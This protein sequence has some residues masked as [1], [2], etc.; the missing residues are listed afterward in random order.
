[1][2]RLALVVTVAACGARA[3]LSTHRT[4]PAPGV[5]TAPPGE[6]PPAA[7]GP[8]TEALAPTYPRAADGGVVLS[9][10]PSPHRERPAPTPPI[11]RIDDARAL[12][13]RRD[14]RPPLVAALAWSSQLVGRPAP[15]VDDAAGLIAWAQAAAAWRSVPALAPG[16]LIVFDRAVGGAPAS[17]VAVALGADDRG[18]V[19]MIYLGAGIVR[20]GFLDV[21][22][23]RLRRDRAGRVVNTALRHNRDQ[24]PKGTRFMAGEL[25]AGVI[26]TAPA[27]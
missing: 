2:W 6:A 22:R 13:G 14:P 8:V 21:T 12:V 26:S 9:R 19:E 16:D 11:D 23:P 5:L 20:R 10:L 1:M 7:A 25:F 4:A 18:V 27:R 17:L 3:P 24:P 15:P